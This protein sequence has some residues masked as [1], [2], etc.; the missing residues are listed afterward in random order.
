MMK[1]LDYLI[2][3]AFGFLLGMLFIVYRIG[4]A[5]IEGESS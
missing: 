4:L 2:V 5:I 1:L 3:F